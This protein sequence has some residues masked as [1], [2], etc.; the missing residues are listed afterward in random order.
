MTHIAAFSASGAFVCRKITN[1][2]AGSA[3][4]ENLTINAALGF[5]PV[6]RISFLCL[7]RFAAD[8]INLAWDRVG[9]AD[10]RASMTGVAV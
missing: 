2:V 1:A 5:T 9:V 4:R 3:G 7:H 6:S 10:C 8:R